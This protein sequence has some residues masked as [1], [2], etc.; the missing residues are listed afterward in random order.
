MMICS[1]LKK[2]ELCLKHSTRQSDIT[3]VD[4]YTAGN[5]SPIDQKEKIKQNSEATEGKT[6]MKPQ[7][8]FIHYQPKQGRSIP[9]DQHVQIQR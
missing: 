9:T 6:N 7:I 4:E 1:A 3:Q 2:K 5:F 8:P